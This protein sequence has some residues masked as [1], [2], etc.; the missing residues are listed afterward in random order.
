MRHIKCYL[1]QASRRKY[2]RTWN[3]NIGRKKKKTEESKR[4]EGSICSNFFNMF[5]GEQINNTRK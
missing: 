2:D 3:S 5:F 4:E 1:N